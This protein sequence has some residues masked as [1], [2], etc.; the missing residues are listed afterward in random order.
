MVWLCVKV[1]KRLF[2]RPL[3]SYCSKQTLWCGF[4][5]GLVSPIWGKAEQKSKEPA[6]SWKSKE[7]KSQMVF[8]SSSLIRENCSG[9]RERSE[10]GGCDSQEVGEMN[11][12]A[13]RKLWSDCSFSLFAIM[14]KQIGSQRAG[15]VEGDTHSLWAANTGGRSCRGERAG[16]NQPSPP[17]WGLRAC[18]SSN[19]WLE[20]LAAVVYTFFCLPSERKQNHYSLLLLRKSEVRSSS[21]KAGTKLESRLW[22]E[23]W[24]PK[25]VLH[26]QTWSEF[27]WLTVSVHI[28]S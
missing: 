22:L 28:N 13:R 4:S 2:R 9:M 16:G 6:E 8:F 14:E 5:L 20:R 23:H 7:E 3:F 26:D 15:L 18:V 19:V 1:F 25:N 21:P 12:Q 27:A 10:K 17:T 11:F 24:P